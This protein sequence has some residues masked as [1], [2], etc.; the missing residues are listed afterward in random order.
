MAYERWSRNWDGMGLDEQAEYRDRKLSRFIRKELYPNSQ[1]YR[2]LFDDNGI[3]P[4][5]IKGVEDLRKVPFTY[6]ED[7][8]AEALKG[9]GI[10][11]SGI[12]QGEMGQG[13]P[14]SG[15]SRFIRTMN[16]WVKGEDHVR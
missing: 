16:R 9:R 2:A 6:R 12:M 10:S 3:D 13:A 1:R 11:P 15:W 14:G 5:A 7:L 4:A 8:V